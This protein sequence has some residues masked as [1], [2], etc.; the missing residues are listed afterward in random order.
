MARLVVAKAVLWRMWLVRAEGGVHRGG[1]DLAWQPRW[2]LK[3]FLRF[4]AKV[5]ERCKNNGLA[6]ARV[7]GNKCCL[8]S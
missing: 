7:G 4:L 3:V 1:V 2:Q 6:K 5:A 8:A